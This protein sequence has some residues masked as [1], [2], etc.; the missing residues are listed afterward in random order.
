MRGRWL[1]GFGRSNDMGEC[2]NR[3]RARVD[4][5]LFDHR[6]VER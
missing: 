3:L 1:E 2:F 6:V 5:L 4:G